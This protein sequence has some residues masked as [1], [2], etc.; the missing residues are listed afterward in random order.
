MWDG[1]IKVGRANG[2]EEGEGCWAGRF[3]T[4]WT[5][6]FDDDDDD[7]TQSMD[8]SNDSYCS[9]FNMS[10]P[11]ALPPSPPSPLHELT[12]H[13][14]PQATPPANYGASRRHMNHPLL[15]QGRQWCHFVILPLFLTSGSSGGDKLVLTDSYGVVVSMAVVL[16]LT[17]G[18][19]AIF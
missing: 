2:V 18:R 10:F 3:T 11:Y 4:G 14:A 13:P 9:D 6:M 1:H 16:G 12:Q 7:G 8:G 19:P 17:L 15:Q 5:P